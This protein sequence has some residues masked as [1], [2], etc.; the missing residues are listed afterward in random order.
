[1]AQISEELERAASVSGAGWGTMF[2]KVL[3]PLIL[4]GIGAGWVIMFVSMMRELS[5][6]IMLFSSQKE[7]VGI[8]LIQLYDEGEFSQVSILSL[9]VVVLSLLS[10]GLV[11]RVLRLGEVGGIS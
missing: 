2:R 8:V 3:V 9:A 10:V 1:M 11:R 4:P 6:S 5:S 7:T